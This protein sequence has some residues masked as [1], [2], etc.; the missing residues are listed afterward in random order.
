MTKEELIDVLS[1]SSPTVEVVLR[2]HA[3]DEALL[4]S[5]RK[6]ENENFELK[7][8]L[9]SLSDCITENLGLRSRLKAAKRVLNL[10]H[11]DSSFLDR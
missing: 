2:R 10:H 8:K 9:D 4:A 1:S 7:R 6:L 11:I 3:D 5:I